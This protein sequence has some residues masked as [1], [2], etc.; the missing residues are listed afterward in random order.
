MIKA[1]GNILI[2]DKSHSSIK[3]VPKMSAQYT[4]LL[5]P[6]ND[7]STTINEQVN[8]LLDKKDLSKYDRV[9]IELQWLY[10]L[11]ISSIINLDTSDISNIGALRIKQGKG[12]ED[13]I[14]YSQRFTDFL[15]FLK[16]IEVGK[17][18]V[19]SRFYYYRLYKKLGLYQRFG[20]NVNMSVTHI[21]RHNVALDMKTSNI[22]KKD[23]KRFLGHK[24]VKSTEKYYDKD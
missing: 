13:L 15:L 18:F 10:G 8:R 19:S 16:K 2:F 7:R 23:V 11:R 22:D 14:I 20:K 9:V 12:S 21:F 17:I 6:D 4:K 3:S 24:N 5:Q 1:S